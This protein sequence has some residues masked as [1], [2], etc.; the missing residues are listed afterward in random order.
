MPRLPGRGGARPSRITPVATSRA[1]PESTRAS[2]AKA[3]RRRSGGAGCA[4]TST[5][6]TL[7]VSGARGV[8]GA[9]GEGGARGVG[10]AGRRSCWW[11]TE[12]IVCCSDRSGA[13]AAPACAG[14]CTFSVTC[15]VLGTGGSAGAVVAVGFHWVVFASER[16]GGRCGGFGG[17]GRWRTGI[18]SGSVGTS[19]LVGCPP[20]GGGGC[21]PGIGASARLGFAPMASDG[22]FGGGGVVAPSC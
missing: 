17:A 18:V 1:S 21:R 11:C 3:P 20:G 14:G 6:S 7:P 8:G 15:R 13:R 12:S 9:R 5:S 19:V 2:T 22:G 16:G 4:S 10:G